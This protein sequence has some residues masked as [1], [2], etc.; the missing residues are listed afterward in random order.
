MPDISV[1]DSLSDIEHSDSIPLDLYLD[2]V[3]NGRW[4][5]IALNIR[6][7]SDK[8]R[9]D[10]MKQTLPGV[11]FSGLFAKR[12]DSG[13]VQ[14]S[15]IICI[16]LDDLEE[17]D[18]VKELLTKDKYVF[19]CF[20][21]ISGNG[22]RVLFRINGAKHRESYYGISD[23]LRR[24]FGLITDPQSMVPSRS[25][26]I[27]YDP[28]L[29]R[30]DQHVPMFTDYPKEKV[31]KTPENFAFAN[32]DFTDILKQVEQ[33]KVNL[34]ETYQDWLKIGFAF[35]N[36][37]GEDGRQYFHLVSSMSEKYNQRQ[38]D[39]QFSYCV[40]HK[41]M[42][43]ATIAS[44]YWYCKQAGLQVTSER[45]QKVRKI[46]LNGKA[47]GLRK[48]QIIEN[49]KKEGVD[50]DD[51]VN[52][53]FDSS[54]DYSAG[55]SLI[56][57]LEMFI[58]SNYTFKKNDISKLIEHFPERKPLYQ[59]DLNTIFIQ[60]K[61]VLQQIDYNLFDRLLHSD[62]IPVY[63]PIREFFESIGGE[64]KR[65]QLP[66]IA[67]GN[68]VEL[69]PSPLIDKLASSIINDKPSFTKYFV[70]K[71]LV[72]VVS[73]AFGK[74]SPLVLVLTG[75]QNS[76]KSEWFRRLM[77]RELRHPVDYYGESKLE[78]GK[79]DEILMCQKLILMDDEYAGKNKKEADR[80]KEL[81]SKQKFSL[82][83]PYGRTNVD[84]DRLAV[85]CGTT[86]EDQ[87]LSDTTG[88]RRILPIE[89]EDVDKSMYNSINKLDLFAEMYKLYN[90]G[91]NWQVDSA[92][93]EY[94]KQNTA[95]YQFVW[96]E[97]E[98]I[99]KF[100]TPSITHEWMGTGEIK[101]E[102]KLLTTI[103]FVPDRIGKHL[104]RLN[105]VQEQKYNPATKS[106]T[107]KWGIMKVNRPASNTFNNFNL[108][109]NDNPQ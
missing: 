30:S 84:L 88:N 9:R 50:A 12:T 13:L 22:L 48:D 8:K 77:P 70:K 87:I 1:F 63:N 66:D 93:I 3:K 79:D 69:F 31:A 7:V 109:T 107:R 62:F 103:D 59:S 11:T 34:C 44:F 104:K 72:S 32:D 74:H 56:E 95:K 57:K 100:Y 42:K 58:Q 76:G 6:R 60:A 10:S 15:G 67:M 97:A 89:V 14:H 33:R 26:Y 61:K 2:E 36:K 102:L 29:Y 20:T 83:E 5:D 106:S 81:T 4:Q 85:L 18:A 41:A 21:S 38:C 49:L 25:F 28:F 24:N 46:T 94:L 35:A 108:P 105:F 99:E 92:D 51:I 43:V 71:W 19:A 73:A 101:M 91:F 23:Y 27:T 65:P 64:W 55:E 17:V 86:N 16:D 45:T 75:K 98:A 52:D 47:A 39:K 80:F 90:D 68:N 96:T 37:F 53:I 40:K 82:R 78:A 54:A